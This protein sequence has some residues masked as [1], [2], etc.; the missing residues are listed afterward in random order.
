M[1]IKNLTIEEASKKMQSG[2]LTSVALVSACIENAKKDNGDI[3]AFLE[4]FD[5]ALAQA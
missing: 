4:I 2:E 5:D 3:N 1:D